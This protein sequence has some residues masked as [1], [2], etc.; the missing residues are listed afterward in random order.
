MFQYLAPETGLSAHPVHILFQCNTGQ[1]NDKQRTG[2]RGP[3]TW[4]TVAPSQGL[5]AHT[6]SFP[7]E[8]PK[9]RIT[10]PFCYYMEEFLD[11]LLVS[12]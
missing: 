9:G 12:P 5:Y 3:W 10:Q 6:V 2:E 7:N 4:Y 8:S 1:A 11:C